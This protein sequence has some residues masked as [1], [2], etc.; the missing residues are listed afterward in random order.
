MHLGDLLCLD[1]NG[2]GLFGP[3]LGLGLKWF[4]LGLGLR[5]VSGVGR[6]GLEQFGLGL[7]LG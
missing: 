3:G 5:F 1:L 6:F 4:G 2:L 7:G